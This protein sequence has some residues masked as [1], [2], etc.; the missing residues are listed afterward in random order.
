MVTVT[1]G[2]PLPPVRGWLFP[3][4]ERSGPSPPRVSTAAPEH[5]SSLP[6]RGRFD[7]RPDPTTGHLGSVPCHGTALTRS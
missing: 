1:H 7:I 2:P 6:P 3:S 4:L 5:R